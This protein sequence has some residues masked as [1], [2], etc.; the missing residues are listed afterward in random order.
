V[1]LGREL[2]RR[3]GDLGAHLARLGRSLGGAVEAYN[4][5]VAS[6]EA[7]VLPAARRFES[8]GAAAQG[9]P[10]AELAPLD[11]AP[12]PLAAAELQHAVDALDA[13]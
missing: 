10:L 12:R 1:A 11:A 8:L 13:P 7:R 9:E 4:R 3:V 6:V 5:A 2:H